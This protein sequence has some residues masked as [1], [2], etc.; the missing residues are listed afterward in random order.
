MTCARSSACFLNFFGLFFAVSCPNSEKN[1]CV[2]SS[3]KRKRVNF[4]LLKISKMNINFELLKV[5]KMT[6][7]KIYISPVEEKLET[8][9]LD[10]G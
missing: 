3:S 6:S 9:N 7:L 10:S 5:S 2:L 4:D 8:S 1:N